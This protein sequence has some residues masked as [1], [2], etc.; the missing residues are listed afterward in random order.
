MSRRPQL[1]RKAAVDADGRAVHEREVPVG[2]GAT[3]T[4]KRDVQALFAPGPRRSGDHDLLRREAR[5]AA[6]GTDLANPARPV[7]S[8][9]A[10]AH[11]EWCEAQDLEP[12]WRACERTE[13]SL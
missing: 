13:W 12:A 7:D 6:D 11:I 3:K 8:E 4:V 1:V 5:L 2:A 10:K 9:V